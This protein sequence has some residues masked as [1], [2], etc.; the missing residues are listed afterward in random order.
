MTDFGGI[1]LSLALVAIAAL[2][3]VVIIGHFVLYYRDRRW[4]G[5]ERRMLK[6]RGLEIEQKQREMVE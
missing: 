3:L 6:T 1:V 5:R 2:N 4:A